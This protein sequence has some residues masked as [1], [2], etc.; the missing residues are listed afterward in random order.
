[1]SVPPASPA[2]SL[3]AG[4]LSA[5]LVWAAVAAGLAIGVCELLKTYLMVD[6]CE[7]PVALM[8]RGPVKILPGEGVTELDPGRHH[9][10]G[11]R[12]L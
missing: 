2:A 4:A 8:S 10:L 6:P 5:A 1:M 9:E 7:L 3:S 12:L 11:R